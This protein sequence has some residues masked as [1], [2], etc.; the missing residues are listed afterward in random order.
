MDKILYNV[1]KIPQVL[2]ISDR[3]QK[4]KKIAQSII[5]K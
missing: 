2:L 1:E 3:F 4:N 5:H